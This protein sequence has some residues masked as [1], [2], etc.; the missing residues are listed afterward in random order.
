VTDLQT[1]VEVN[2]RERH[3]R[4]LSDE[5]FVAEYGASR[6][7][8][9]VL[10]NRARY[11]TEHICTD[12]L[13]RAFSPIIS[14]NQDFAGA[15]LGPPELGYPLAA[16]NK[17]NP[18]FLG[19]LSTGV[20]GMA[21]EFG[22]ERMGP[23]DLVICNDPFRVGNHVNDM[24]FMRPVFRDG[25]LV[26]FLVIRAH[27]LDIGGTVP[28]GF[29]L[30]KMNVYETGLV[31]APQLMFK[32]DE[33]VRETI[34]M[35]LDNTRFGE[36]IL[37]DFFTIR[38]CLAL[39][40]QL[41]QETLDHYGVDAWTG[42][43]RY[44]LD[45]S[46][47]SM[48]RAIATLPDGEYEGEDV[49]DSDGV[50]ADEEYRVHVKLIKRGDQLEVDLSGSSRQSRTAL[51]ATSLDAQTGVGIALKLLLDPT[52]P[53][54]SGLYRD[55]DIAIPQ[56]TV[57]SARPEAG[58]MFFWEPETSLINALG[59]ALAEPLGARAVA[60]SYGST[61]LH[62]GQGVTSDGTPWFTAAELEAAYGAWGAT[63][64]GDADSHSSIFYLNMK[65]TPTE[66]I[67]QR[68]PVL[69]MAREY[70]PD[71]GGPGTHRG[72]AGFRKD[73]LFLADG[74]HYLVPLHYRRPSGYGVHGGKEGRVGGA[75]FFENDQVEK[76]VA[77]YRVPDV[78]D[79]AGAAVVSGVVDEQGRLDDDG[80]FAFF[81]RRAIWSEPAGS[82]LRWVTNGGGGWGDP[83]ERDVDAVVRDVRDGYVS[84]AGAERDYGV[85]ITGDP[86]N[87]PEALTV[88]LE[89][90]RRL[91]E[92]R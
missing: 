60:G 32:A 71:T 49:I 57:A 53:F 1:T 21:M 59:R 27:Q 12:L 35:M 2:L 43:I 36:M 75:W 15:I 5:E 11:I 62:T 25:R 68:V 78:D 81:G 91:R 38:S 46:A 82:L 67:E 42:A 90:T 52:S 6:F 19:T 16:V 30:M 80:D 87:D 10:A 3:L 4:D 26:T 13:Y 18:G 7:T 79:Y 22:I 85:A 58:V 84:I 29:G 54:T 37:P 77:D 14:W 40:E 55:I 72:G 20:K 86:H 34:K 8:C 23:G 28:G 76:P 70:L 61:N 9:G 83:F 69:L 73:S 92:A 45:A 33:P 44:N 63:D 65:I 48:R 41:V 56:G 51:N 24:C 50:D 39:G 17:G 66:E 88:D 74:D 89:A 31:M 64:A 47:E